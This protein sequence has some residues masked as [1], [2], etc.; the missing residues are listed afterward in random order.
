MV[1]REGLGLNPSSVTLLFHGCERPT[2]EFHKI[3]CPTIS[4][5]PRKLLTARGAIYLFIYL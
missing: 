5:I 4:G 1:D 2:K 3:Q